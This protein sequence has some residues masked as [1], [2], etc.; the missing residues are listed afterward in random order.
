MSRQ[1]TEMELRVAKAAY[2]A[3]HLPW[4]DEEPWD[5]A[6]DRDKEMHLRAAR[7]AIRVWKQMLEDASPPE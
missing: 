6:S 7:A 4:D 3:N 5:N 1:P 2:A